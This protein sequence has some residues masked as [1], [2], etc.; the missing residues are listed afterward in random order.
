MAACNSL[1]AAI[2]TPRLKIDQQ[3]EII[4][5]WLCIIQRIIFS[6]MCSLPDQRHLVKIYI[7]KLE[8]DDARFKATAAEK[9]DRTDARKKLATQKRLRA[10][11]IRVKTEDL[12]D[13]MTEPIWLQKIICAKYPALG[14]LSTES[15][16]NFKQEIL[17][18]TDLDIIYTNMETIG[19]GRGRTPVG[20]FTEAASQFFTTYLGESH[21][22]DDQIM[23][24]IWNTFATIKST[25]GSLQTYQQKRGRKM[26]VGSDRFDT[27][28]SI[29]E[30]IR[31][32]DKHIPEKSSR[33]DK[34]VTTVTRR[35]ELGFFLGVRSVVTQVEETDDMSDMASSIERLIKDVG[36]S[37]IRLTEILSINKGHIIANIWKLFQNFCGNDADYIAT[38]K[39][40]FRGLKDFLQDDIQPLMSQIDQ[41]HIYLAEIAKLKTRPTEIDVQ[42]ELTRR[43]FSDPLKIFDISK[44]RDSLIQLE[45]Q[46]RDIL[47]QMSNNM[48]PLEKLAELSNILDATM[49]RLEKIVN[50]SESRPGDKSRLVKFYILV[51]KWKT[52]YSEMSTIEKKLILNYA[53]EY[54]LH[55]AWMFIEK[56][57]YKKKD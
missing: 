6:Y 32:L 19:G 52:F 9:L 20:S 56:A 26:S 48:L 14:K 39:S 3:S 13:M 42:F 16:L 53:F 47:T 4:E 44:D 25:Y 41:I 24:K 18:L 5:Q 40:A 28:L 31:S 23:L 17:A 38:F 30:Q 7:R 45:Q 49:C 15:K 10:Q 2:S 34:V 54:N 35:S 55:Q 37:I 12:T 36:I 43:S 29:F 27:P 51:E 46:L 22:L 8:Q 21:Q 50:A 33:D 1:H 57:S 11:F